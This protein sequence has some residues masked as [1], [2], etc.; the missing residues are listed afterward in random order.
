MGVGGEIHLLHGV[1]EVAFA[2][3]IELAAF[4]HLPRAHGGV[5]DEICGF[6]TLDLDLAGGGDAPADYRRRF[7][8]ECVRGEFLEID[9]R[10]FD[11]DVDAGEQGGGDALAV[12]FDLAE[13]PG[14]YPL[15]HAGRSLS[16]HPLKPPAPHHRNARRRPRH[17]EIRCQRQLRHTYRIPNEHLRLPG[18]LL[19]FHGFRGSRPPAEHPP[20]DRRHRFHTHLLATDVNINSW[21]PA[22]NPD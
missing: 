16:H 19:P 11:V 21:R 14:E 8:G 2:F 20:L 1:F 17:G 7:S 18:R 12:V 6:E 3:R 5:G 9:E 4:A 22:N 10:D 15:R 13:K